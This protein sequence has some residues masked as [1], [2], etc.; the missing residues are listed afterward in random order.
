MILLVSPST[1]LEDEGCFD[2]SKGIP[3]TSPP[4]KKGRAKEVIESDEETDVEMKVEEDETLDKN[5]SNTNFPT[6]VSACLHPSVQV[7]GL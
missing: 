5:L 3:V 2:G 6:V 4:P 7:E 1:F